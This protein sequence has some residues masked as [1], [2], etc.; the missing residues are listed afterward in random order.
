MNAQKY[1]RKK[2]KL[3]EVPLSPCNPEL[4][5]CKKMDGWIYRCFK[6]ANVIVQPPPPFFFMA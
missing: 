5:M 6:N 1:W 4:V 2:G 3:N